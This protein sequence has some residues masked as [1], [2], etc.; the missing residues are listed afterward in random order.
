MLDTNGGDSDLTSVATVPCATAKAL[1]ARGRE[2]AS[3]KQGAPFVVPISINQ[4]S[5]ELNN[6]PTQ[7]CS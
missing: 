5:V 2:A 7:D 3:A 6:L 1:A 4:R